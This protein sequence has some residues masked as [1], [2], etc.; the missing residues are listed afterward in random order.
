MSASARIRPRSMPPA[1]VVS[2][3]DPTLTTTRCAAAIASRIDILTPRACRRTVAG[4]PRPPRG[5]G[6]A[7]VLGRMIGA[8]TLTPAD[9]RRPLLGEPGVLTAPTQDLGSDVDLRGEVEDHSIG[10]ADRHPITC[11]STELE[12]PIL[13][14]NAVEPIG[15]VAD[16]FVIAEVGLPHP[17]LGLLTTHSPEVTV[18]LNLEL[19]LA[20]DP[21]GWRRPP[22]PPHHAGQLRPAQWRHDPP[23]RPPTAHFSYFLARTTA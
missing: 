13:D 2:D 17:A 19:R 18:T 15:E 21:H 14:A 3:D 9:R 7:L 6:P 8:I 1:A 4:C 12:E 10:T 11:P 16:G 5:L 22:G 20:C 23:H